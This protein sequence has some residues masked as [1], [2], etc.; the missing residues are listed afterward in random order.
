MTSLKTNSDFNFNF[1]Y[2]GLTSHSN[3][4]TGLYKSNHHH[5]DLFLWTLMTQ[6]TI[7][8]AWIRIC[9]TCACHGQQSALLPSLPSLVHRCSGFPRHHS[10]L[11]SSSV[12]LQASRGRGEWA[13]VGMGLSQRVPRSI[14]MYPRYRACSTAVPVK[15]II[16][17]FGLWLLYHDVCCIGWLMLSML[18]CWLSSWAD[19]VWRRFLFWADF[20]V[21]VWWIEWCCCRVWYWVQWLVWLNGMKDNF[22]FFEGIFRSGKWGFLNFILF[23]FYFLF[24]ILLWVLWHVLFS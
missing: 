6:A 10:L 21:F 7:S 19:V 3:L 24:V 22:F 18:D 17:L 2:Y 5:F 20:S 4:W 11:G 1:W 15:I 13:A 9:M 16:L 12:G 23:Y 14:P 8:K